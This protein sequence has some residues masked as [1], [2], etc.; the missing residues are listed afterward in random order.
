MQHE[1]TPVNIVVLKDVDSLQKV[2]LASNMSHYLLWHLCP[3]QIALLL[4]Y[5]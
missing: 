5:V 2:N 1:G 3:T 4:L